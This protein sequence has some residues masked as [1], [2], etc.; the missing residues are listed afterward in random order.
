MRGGVQPWLALAAPV[1]VAGLCVP[2]QLCVPARGQ[3]AS[4]PISMNKSPSPFS[5]YSLRN[6]RSLRQG[7]RGVVVPSR[8]TELAP[9][10]PTDS[11][12]LA[13]GAAGFLLLA[14]AQLQ[15][16]LL[17]NPLASPL[18]LAKFYATVWWPLVGE[19]VA[20]A[21][22]AMAMAMLAG[23]SGI[24]ALMVARGLSATLLAGRQCW[25]AIARV[26]WEA[27]KRKQRYAATRAVRVKQMVERKAERKQKEAEELEKIAQA[28]FWAIAT[29]GALGA[30][31]KAAAFIGAAGA[32]AVTAVA[33]DEYEASKATS[34]QDVPQDTTVETTTTT[35]ASVNV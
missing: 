35:L 20:S 12:W 33:L 22:L 2:F 13:A 28:A 4:M 34:K 24:S 17:G 27:A 26:T 29:G 21:M 25:A 11:R 7:L 3:G 19:L 5:Q 16:V 8:R 31:V 32:T 14:G 9:N 6:M 30:V 23:A 1:T 10:R 18:R 15:L